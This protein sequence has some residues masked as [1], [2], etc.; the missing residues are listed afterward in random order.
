MTSLKISNQ[1]IDSY[2]AASAILLVLSLILTQVLDFDI[3]LQNFLFVN[4]TW[5]IDKDEIVKK[6][7]FY[8]LPKIFFGVAIAY[9]LVQ[10]IILYRKRNSKFHAIFLTFLG[11]ALIPLIAGNVKKFTNIY[12]P[13]QLEI[14]GEHK[15][16]VKIFDKYPAGFKQE[17]KGKCFPAG[18]AV[19]GFAL[20][21]LFF[22]LQG[23]ARIYGFG[24]A[25][26]LGWIL[27]FYQMAK[28]AH[29]FSDTWVA[30]LLCFL[31]AA[32]IARVYQSFLAKSTF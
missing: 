24:A 8:K 31:L 29:F 12:C 28:G 11:F 13:N 32:A 6:I 17:K 5:L 16:Y 25:M 21:I 1:S 22:S 23:N 26:I 19:T 3:Y 27:G 4:N 9:L 30:M 7:I 2:I 20:F 14:Y 18:H 10:S 15:P